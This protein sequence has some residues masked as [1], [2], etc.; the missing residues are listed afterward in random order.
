MVVFNIPVVPTDDEARKH[1]ENLPGMGGVY[2]VVNLH[3]YHYAGNNPVKYVDPDGNLTIDFGVYASA[4]AGVGGSVAGGFS[5]GIS[6]DEG[7]TFGIFTSEDIG[8]DFSGHA[9]LGFSFSPNIFAKKVESSVTNQL[10][11]GGSFTSTPIIGAGI[12]AE[13]VTDLNTS[14]TSIEIIGSK[15][16]SLVPEVPCFSISLKGNIA[17]VEAH[18]KVRSTQKKQLIQINGKTISNFFKNASDFIKTSFNKIFDN[19][20]SN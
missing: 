15:G 4:G 19:S 20:Q 10:I 16:K 17:P 18:A 5:I 11:V 1:N 14:E 13:M 3:L 9:E 8:A 2:N 7:F 6:L 12:G